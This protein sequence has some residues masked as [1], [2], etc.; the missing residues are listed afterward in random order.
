MSELHFDTRD[1]L[2]EVEGL[3]KVVIGAEL[4][5]VDLVGGGRAGRGHDD[6]NGRVALADERDEL[7]AGH[8]GEHKVADHHDKAGA[9]VDARLRERGFEEQARLRARKRLGTGI[10]ASGK[11][12]GNEVV[13]VGVV[14][15]DEHADIC[16]GFPFGVGIWR[17]V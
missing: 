11:V 5:Q 16:H 10:A 12:R 15:D 9:V 8:A 4:E 3:G 2:I 1:K 6:G 7:L 13:D 17:D 14:L